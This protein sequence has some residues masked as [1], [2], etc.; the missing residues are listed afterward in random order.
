MANQRDVEIG[1]QRLETLTDG[2]FA[3]VMTLL[4]LELS[5]PIISQRSLDI[6][7]IPRLIELWPKFYSYILSF[8]LTGMLW[9]GNRVEYRYIKRSDGML[10]MLTVIY[11]MFL[12]LLPFTTSVVGAYPLDK[13]PLLIFGINFAAILC[14]RIAIWRY[15]VGEHRLV[16]PDLSP[17][18][19]HTNTLIP[20]VAI[21]VAFINSLIAFVSPL[22]AIIIYYVLVL[23]YLMVIVKG[24]F[25]GLGIR[26]EK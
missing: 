12:T 15:A 24:A 26:R 4:A 6:Q 7:L 11:L 22:A 23:F 13:L 5:L 14:S 18:L 21:M 9:N 8:L 20:L 10:V 25:P 3:I 16:D 2:V 17:Q 1:T 19:I